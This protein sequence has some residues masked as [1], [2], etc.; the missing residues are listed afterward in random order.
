MLVSYLTEQRGIEKKGKR[1]KINSTW[2]RER[3]ERRKRERKREG[4]GERR[5]RVKEKE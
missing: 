5:N 3:K 2:K 4:E 1:G